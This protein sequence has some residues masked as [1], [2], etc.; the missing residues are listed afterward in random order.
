MIP[1]T[2]DDTA[3][4]S[5]EKKGILGLI[6]ADVDARIVSLRLS[7]HANPTNTSGRV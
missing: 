3:Q 6:L 2:N 1:A 5:I 7:A 4:L